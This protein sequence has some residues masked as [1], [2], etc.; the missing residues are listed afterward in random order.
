MEEVV[1]VGA[2]P[3]DDTADIWGMLALT[4]RIERI[5]SVS[6]PREQPDSPTSPSYPRQ[7]LKSALSPFPEPQDP[8][9]ATRKLNKA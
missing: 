6:G 4:V 5:C 3:G 1:W 8:Q 9:Q 2:A 7:Q